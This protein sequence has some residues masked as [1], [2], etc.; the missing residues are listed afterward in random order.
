MSN[1]IYSADTVIA[2]EQPS[3][4]KVSFDPLRH[5]YQKEEGEL[6]QLQNKRV[7]IENDTLVENRTIRKRLMVLLTAASFIWLS[8]TGFIVYHLAFRY[9][10]LSDAVAIAFI[11]TSLATVL[12]LWAIGLRYFFAQDIQHSSVNKRQ[13]QR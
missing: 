9:C 4:V 6:R 2:G 10:L 8:F 12:G 1:Q 7:S 11:T 5:D 13:K 3:T